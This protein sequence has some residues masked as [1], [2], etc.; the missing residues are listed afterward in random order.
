MF[1]ISRGHNGCRKKIIVANLDADVAF[2]EDG[3]GRSLFS[4][5]TIGFS[6]I[7]HHFVERSALVSAR[8]LLGSESASSADSEIFD[9][10]KGIDKGFRFFKD[11]HV[12]K[13]EASFSKNR[14]YVCCNVLPSM[15]KDTVYKYRICVGTGMCH[16]QSC[17]VYLYSWPGWCL[18]PH[19]CPPLCVGRVRTPWASRRR[20]YLA[21]FTALQMES[22]TVPQGCT[23]LT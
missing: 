8:Q 14:T 22:A 7:Y 23:L 5:P 13:I 19:C 10:A 21:N 16:S 6:T 17:T 2:P 1:L 18:Q 15:K 4:L 3:W 11:G 20:W 12:Q 9:S